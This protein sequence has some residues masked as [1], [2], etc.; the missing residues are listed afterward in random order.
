MEVL[1][2]ETMSTQFCRYQ[3][4]CTK[5][6]VMRVMHFSPLE[7][8]CSCALTTAQDTPVMADAQELYIK[9]RSTFLQFS[10]CHSLHD[11]FTRYDTV[12]RQVLNISVV[13]CIG[14][15]PFFFLII[16]IDEA[17]KML[18]AA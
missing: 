1:L 18:F 14:C 17:I 2:L 12:P 3:Y 15:E 11:H 8:L 9:F 10:K 13:S 16:C 4:T 7:A 5:C 6:D